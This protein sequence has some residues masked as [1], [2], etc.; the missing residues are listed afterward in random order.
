MDSRNFCVVSMDFRNPC[1][2]T[3]KKL[4]REEEKNTP[5]QYAIDVSLSSFCSFSGSDDETLQTHIQPNKLALY[6]PAT[7][8]ANAN[9]AAIVRKNANTLISSLFDHLNNPV[10]FPWTYPFNHPPRVLPSVGIFIVQCANCFKWRLIPSK[11][12]YEDIREHILEVPFY[13]KTASEWWDFVSCD[14]PE[15]IV[16]DGS[17]LWAIDRPNI[18]QLPPRW[19]RLLR[20]KGEGSTRFVDVYV[21]YDATLSYSSALPT[22]NLVL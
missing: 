2:I 8:A 9:S 11:E 7:A 17:R 12:K 18:A 13:Y 10:S 16:Q 1:K 14:D 22:C 19:Q 3:F 21:I 15:D 5:P 20:I 4:T 6:H